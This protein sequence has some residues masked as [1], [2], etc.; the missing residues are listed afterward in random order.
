MPGY[1]SGSAEIHADITRPVSLPAASLALVVGGY[2]YSCPPLVV[3]RWWL[4]GRSFWRLDCAGV[5]VG[6]VWLGLDGNVYI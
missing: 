4:V 5:G 6:R 1:L 2:I 3:G